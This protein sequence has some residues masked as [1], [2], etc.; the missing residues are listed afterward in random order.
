MSKE[1]IPLSYEVFTQIM[2][3]F[4]QMYPKIKERNDFLAMSVV[5]E[6]GNIVLKLTLIHPVVR[7]EVKLEKLPKDFDVPLGMGQKVNV[8]LNVHIAP[9][10]PNASPKSIKNL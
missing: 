10:L 6:A 7:P 3:H 1:P 5:K 2:E 4:N 9:V 8:K